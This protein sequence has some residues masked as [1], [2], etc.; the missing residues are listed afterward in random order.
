MLV[1]HQ[2]F[3]VRRE[4]APEYDTAYRWVAD[5]EWCIRCLKRSKQI[6]HTHRILSNYLEEGLS[7]AHRKDSLKERYAVMCRY[8]G[9]V[10]TVLLHGW[11]AVRFYAAKWF[12][13][14][15]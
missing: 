1:C 11:F 12:K 2:S 7:T 4:I 5:Y 8:Y 15:V 3:V 9:K 10:T 14:G 6:R 13:G